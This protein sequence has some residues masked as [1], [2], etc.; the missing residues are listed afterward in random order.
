MLQ[1]CPRH[2]SLWGAP[3]H[4]Y[5]SFGVFPLSPHSLHVCNLSHFPS[6][7]PD[8]LRLLQGSSTVPKAKKKSF[9]FCFEVKNT[10]KCSSGHTFPTQSPA[11][12]IATFLLQKRK[13]AGPQP[14]GTGLFLSIK[15]STVPQADLQLSP[16]Q[17]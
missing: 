6:T 8:F 11:C 15:Q 2:T 7:P 3:P 16:S 17:R 13:A 10:V 9:P 5:L 12:Y 4:S 1:L 14:G